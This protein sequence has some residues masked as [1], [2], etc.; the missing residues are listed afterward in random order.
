MVVLLTVRFLVPLKE[1]ASA[2]LHLA[3]FTHEVLR[4]PG[5]AQCSYNLRDYLLGFMH[6]AELY[7]LA[8]METQSDL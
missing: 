7:Y 2:Q 6:L 8:K 3:H 5:P 1:V 4:V